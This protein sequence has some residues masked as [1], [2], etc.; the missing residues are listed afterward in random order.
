MGLA[1]GKAKK[2]ALWMEL[3]KSEAK[4]AAEDVAADEERKLLAAEAS[5]EGEKSDEGV[6]VGNVA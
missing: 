1:I 4:K 5:G 2:L 3:S 6:S